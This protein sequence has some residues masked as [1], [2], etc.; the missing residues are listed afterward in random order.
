MATTIS[1]QNK[2]PQTKTLSI[3]HRS[4]AVADPS[5]AAEPIEGTAPILHPAPER[6]SRRLVDRFSRTDPAL[7]SPRDF[8]L[9]QVDPRHTVRSIQ[10]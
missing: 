8:V 10:R 3:V 9:A 5:V 7:P 6:P 2:T 4:S 1:P